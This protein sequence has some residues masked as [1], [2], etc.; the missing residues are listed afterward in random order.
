MS[1]DPKPVEPRDGDPD[2][3]VVMDIG[4]P[5]PPGTPVGQTCWL[6]FD[7]IKHLLPNVPLA[8]P[9]DPSPPH[10]KRSS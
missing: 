1:D 8:R 6:P 7:Q 3:W 10:K 9:G 5:A 4:E 2:D